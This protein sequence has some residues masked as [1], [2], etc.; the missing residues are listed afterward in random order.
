MGSV[1]LAPIRM[2]G[3]RHLGDT[4]PE[5]LRVDARFDDHLGRELHTRATLIKPLV[6]LLSKAAKSAIH[7]VY[8]CLEPLADKQRE[9]RIPKPAM[10]E[11]HCPGPPRS[12]ARR[13]PTALHEVVVL[14]EFLHE[15]WDLL[16]IVAVVRV[17][18]DHVT[19]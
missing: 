6:V 5:P 4:H 16:K 2:Q 12:P 11:G 10:Q 17:T 8:R 9:H 7:V 15:F 19:P 1:R 3:Y 13:Q 14:A 18:H